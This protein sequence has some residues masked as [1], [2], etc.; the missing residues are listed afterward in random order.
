V[1]SVTSLPPSCSAL[2]T[3]CLKSANSLESSICTYANFVLALQTVE[4]VK[5]IFG[6]SSFSS[7]VG[8]IFD[9]DEAEAVVSF[10]YGGEC[11]LDR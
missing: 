3:W 5:N 8:W 4:A 11:I 7:F 9:E 2:T 10:P 6:A 1:M